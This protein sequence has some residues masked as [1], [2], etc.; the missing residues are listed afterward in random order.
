M[1]L[2][3]TTTAMTKATIEQQLFDK[4]ERLLIEVDSLKRRI[5]SLE[6]NQRV[7]QPYQPFGI[8]LPN[9][10]TY[11]WPTNHC[12]KCGLQ[13]DKVMSYCCPQPNCPTGLGPVMCT[14]DTP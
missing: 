7:T 4:L 14:T 9:P 1:G 8:P 13:L 5:E 10:N 11:Q 3:S 12:T 2:T 6:Q